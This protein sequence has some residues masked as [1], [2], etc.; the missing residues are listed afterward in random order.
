MTNKLA[1]LK[2]IDTATVDIQVAGVLFDAHDFN[3]LA[4]MKVRKAIE[5]NLISLLVFHDKQIP[6]SRD[7]GE[8]YSLVESYLPLDEEDYNLLLE[9]SS[10]YAV[11]EDRFSDNDVVDME[12]LEQIIILQEYISTR[13]EKI[14]M[15][16]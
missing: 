13:A 12:H 7:L 3:D 15:S 4:S 6:S 2:L 9:A 5:M 1:A 16:S 8:I 11:N 10:R 14:I